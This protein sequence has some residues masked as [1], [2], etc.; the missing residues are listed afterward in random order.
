[1][2]HTFTNVVGM[3]DYSLKSL[4][5]R[6]NEKLEAGYVQIGEINST[7]MNI[8]GDKK[9]AVRVALPQTDLEKRVA[10]LERKVGELIRLSNRRI[11]GDY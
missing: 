3:T 1:M 4:Q 9:Y 11:E 8:Y 6:L 2:N 7:V 5:K 10:S